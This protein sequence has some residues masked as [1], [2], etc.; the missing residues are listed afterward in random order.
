MRAILSGPISD[1]SRILLLAFGRRE[2]AVALCTT[3]CNKA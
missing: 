3:R 1:S 2:F